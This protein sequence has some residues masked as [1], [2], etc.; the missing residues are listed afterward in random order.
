MGTHER[1]NDID[2]HSSR[3]VVCEKDSEFG[4]DMLTKHIGRFLSQWANSPASSTIKSE[5]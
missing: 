1:W 4:D 5:K 2:C 3:T